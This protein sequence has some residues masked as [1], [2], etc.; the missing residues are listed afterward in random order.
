MKNIKVILLDFD[1]TLADTMDVKAVCFAQATQEYHPEQKLDLNK[2][3]T[4]YLEHLGKIRFE[5][6]RVVEKEYQLSPLDEQKTT[7]WSNRFTQLFSSKEATLFPDTKTTLFQLK[8][9]GYFLGISSTIPQKELELNVKH[10]NLSHLF[11]FILGMSSDPH[12]EKVES[13]VKEIIKH[14]EKKNIIITPQQ[15][16]FVDDSPVQINRAFDTGLFTIKINNSGREKKQPTK[17]DLTITKLSELLDYFEKPTA[18]MDEKLTNK[19]RKQ[20]ILLTGGAG[21]IGSH[22]ADTL[23]ERGDEVLCVDNLNNYYSPKTKIQNISHNFENPLFHFYVEDIKNKDKIAKIFEKHK[24]DKIIHLAARAGVPASI[25][26]PLAYRES[27]VVGT[28][29]IL[30]LAKEFGIKNIVLAS[31]SSVYWG[32]ERLPFSEDDNS[33]DHPVNP[34]AASKKACEI[35]AHNYSQL[36]NMKITCLRYFTVYGPRNRPDMAV[37]LWADSIANGKEITLYGEGDEVKRD[38]TYIKDIVE[39]TLKALERNS[40]KQFEI[41]NIGNGRPVPIKYMVELLEQ[42]LGKKANIVR[43]SLRQGDFPINYADT[44][45]MTNVLG[46]KPTTQIEDGIKDFVAWFKQ[47]KGL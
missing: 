34:Y 31:S 22:I 41:L 40:D 1:G 25:L 10:H 14:L 23:L 3:A 13:H 37:Y 20:T 36:C 17:Q 21:F 28:V 42:A 27:N 5:Q 8:Q 4:L 6:L 7:Q 46:W 11:D 47:H 45:K 43:H 24:I 32:G 38:W 33:T 12:F 15:I 30:Q 16:A 39:G 35:Y 18:T 44:T 2:L 19:N 9:K 29:N 26:D